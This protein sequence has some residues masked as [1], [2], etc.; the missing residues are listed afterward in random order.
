MVVLQ[1]VRSW[2][3]PARARTA[4]NTGTCAVSQSSPMLQVCC[5]CVANGRRRTTLTTGASGPAS[6]TAPR[7]IRS[8]YIPGRWLLYLLS[9]VTIDH[10]NNNP[11]VT[12]SRGFSTNIELVLELESDD[13]ETSWSISK[14]PRVRESTTCGKAF[15]ANTKAGAPR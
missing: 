9:E 7:A 11:Y 3:L 13:G 5:K 1:P 8:T 10:A 4:D 14:K 6:S 15:N 12:I 2:I